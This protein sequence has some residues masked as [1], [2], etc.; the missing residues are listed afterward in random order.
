MGRH[1][2]LRLASPMLVVLAGCGSPQDTPARPIT[3]RS[4]LV[5]AGEAALTPTA[6]NDR[7]EQVMNG[8]PAD[9]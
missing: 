4:D 6:V 3:S 8:V 5:E 9:I 2:L 1:R 7:Y